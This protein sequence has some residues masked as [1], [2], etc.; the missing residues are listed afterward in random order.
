MIVRSMLPQ[1]ID[2]TVI[3]CG[4]Y[5]QEANIGEDYDEN[6]VMETIRQHSIHNEYFW[7]NAYEGQRPVGLVAG[8]ITQAPWSKTQFHVHIE[9][10]FLL[11]SHRTF[12]NFKL[13]LDKVE[14]FAR[15][16]KATKIT[17]GDIGIDI[18]RTKK[19]YNHFDFKEGLWMSK[20]IN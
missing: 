10:I 16:V 4:Y 13:L 17:A 12:S 20:E 3:L 6:A 19:L 7:F 8:A 9:L 14:E 1:E 5:A 2:A 15:S 11:E 18:E